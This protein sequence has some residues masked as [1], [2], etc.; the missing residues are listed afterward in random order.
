MDDKKIV[1]DFRGVL[2]KH[3]AFVK[4]GDVFVN[5][6]I[7]TK[8][9]GVPQTLLKPFADYGV[10]NLMPLFSDFL[11]WDKVV[12]HMDD[13]QLY[14]NIDFATNPITQDGG[15]MFDAYLHNIVAKNKCKGDS[16]CVEYE[17]NF[18]KNIETMDS[19]TIASFLKHKENKEYV[20]YPVTL[21]QIDKFIL[22]VNQ[23]TET[24]SEDSDN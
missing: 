8:E 15:I 4:R 2:L 23:S 6:Q 24:Q 1:V 12:L 20:E 21:T 7:K 19:K 16:T 18:V 14:F 3:S 13:Y 22:G 5:V 10:E 17:F 11:P 9:N